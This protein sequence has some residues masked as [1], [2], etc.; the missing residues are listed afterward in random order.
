[1]SKA[2]IIRVDWGEDALEAMWTHVEENTDYWLKKTRNFRENTLKE[3]ARLYKGTPLSETKNTPWPNAA[4]N[5]IQLIATH[6]DQLLSRVMAIYMMEPLW[7][8]KILGDLDNPES[9]EDQR[10]VFET[11]LS[12]M[13]MKPDELDFYRVEQAWFS[14]AIRNGTG[15][16][17]LPWQYMVEDQLIITEGADPNKP[18]HR[19]D[20]LIKYDG[21][22]PEN[23][24]L[25]K[26]VT[27]LN[28]N[29]LDDS[30]FKFE[31][32]T[33]SK[34]QLE[35][36]KELGIFDHADIDAII[37]QPDRGGKAILQ[38]YIES[39]QGLVDDS[40]GTA[41]DEYDLME[42]WFTYWHNGKKHSLVAIHH[43]LS[44]TRMIAF[45][46]YYPKNMCI[47]E[48]AKLAY[49]DDQYLG[50]GFAEMLKG[51]QD[52]ISVAHNQR[53]DAGT[54]NNTTAF[55]VNKNSKL[56]SILTFY[57]G[58]MVPAD[59]DEI[60]RLDTSN[61]HAQDTNSENLTSAY[62]KER[63]GIDPATG[64]TGGGIVNNKRGIYS[65]QGTFA[66]MQQQNNRTGLRTSDMRSAHTR[67]GVKFAAMYAHFG[68]GA[69]LASYGKNVDTL[70]QAFRNVK[71]GKLGLLIRP[72]SASINKEMEKQNDILM[73]QTLERLYAG[74]AQ[75]IQSLTTAGMPPELK[76]YYIDV[77]KAKNSLMRHI[78]R[79]F[80][81]DDVERLI[82][83]PTFLK[84]SK[85]GTTAGSS[86][87]AQS[88][89]AGV[90][91][92]GGVQTTSAQEGTNSG[93]LPI[94]NGESSNRVPS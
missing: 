74:D 89:G 45:Y 3:Y 39:T 86:T 90:G 28:F 27:N 46:N 59:K 85:N 24:P 60:E 56:H 4:N 42:C 77:L 78:L 1:L 12:D 54:L 2:R 22:R 29:K 6:S 65:S 26:F 37:A 55:R 88:A 10:A 57:P 70:Q 14:S 44:Q 43:P 51:Y 20:E 18:L 63:S 68:I 94:G 71:S 83:E 75:I 25:N 32:V 31:I 76:A 17:K 23:V 21:P 93:S 33:V 87:G 16:I 5:I 48:D 91:G 61:M 79:N 11:F 92:A 8:A 9:G 80:G 73:S 36:R 66:V 58:V 7:A 47:Y 53:T 50:Y 15:I 34:Y 69:K 30:N 64:G 19:F 52:E 62:A 81:H 40:S 38:Q 49:D 13:A 67:A 41:G 82:P 84:E 35:E 72:A